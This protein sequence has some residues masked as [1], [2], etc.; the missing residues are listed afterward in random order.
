MQ[1]EDYR[2]DYTAVEQRLRQLEAP[3][4]RDRLVGRGVLVL[5][6]AAAICGVLLRRR[7]ESCG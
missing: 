3:A 2:Y 7:A 4:Y 5:A 6:I 1:P